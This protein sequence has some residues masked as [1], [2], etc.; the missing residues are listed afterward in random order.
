MLNEPF[1]CFPASVPLQKMCSTSGDQPEQ[2]LVSI[3]ED[4]SCLMLPVSVLG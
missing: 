1:P 2:T 3:G 4:S